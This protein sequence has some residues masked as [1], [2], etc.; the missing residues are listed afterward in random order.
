MTTTHGLSKEELEALTPAEREA[1]EAEPSEDEAKLAAGAPGVAAEA[2]PLDGKEKV[3]EVVD[4]H[5]EKKPV[6]AAV[7]E[8]E[9]EPFA[10]V[11]VVAPA[12]DLEK[13]EA[14]R[15]EAETK[16]TEAKAALKTRFDA[17]EIELDE[18]L[19]ER[20]A[21]SKR[22]SA[23][24]AEIDRRVHEAELA[25]RHEVE[26]EK[27]TW[28]SAVDD[29]MEKNP[30]YKDPVLSG[31]LD[32]RIKALAA[33]KDEAGKLVN[34]KLSNR[35]L[36]DRAHQEV[37]KHFKNG[38]EAPKPAKDVV[39]EAKAARAPDL[40]GVPHTLAGVPA[41]APANA[42]ADEFAHLDALQA[43][44]DRGDAQAQADLERAIAGLN[45]AQEDRYLYRATA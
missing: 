3:T 11:P 35:Q 12:V 16:A 17:G 20:E 39:K 10:G 7:V 38:A 14:A 2:D 22:E 43:K 44:A 29:F 8:E 34:E 23:T 30:V 4:D 15:A 36:L 45:K 25:E 21:V 32:S 9:R 5:E 27:R 31:A 28:K 37:A 1:I 42:E 40:S 33:E 24:I 13:A 41:A 6:E 18:Y 19:N 26:I